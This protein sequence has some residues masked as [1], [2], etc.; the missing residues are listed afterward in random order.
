MYVH[1]LFMFP[2]CYMFLFVYS[3]TSPKQQNPKK[4]GGGLF[5]TGLFVGLVSLYVEVSLFV[6][7]DLHFMLRPV[8]LWD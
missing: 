8:F 7:L 3:G 2:L 4:V 6:G 1:V 5:E